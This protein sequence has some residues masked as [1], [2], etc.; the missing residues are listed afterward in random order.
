MKEQEGGDIDNIVK[1]VE[2]QSVMPE[3]GAVILQRV[4]KAEEIDQSHHDSSGQASLA[5][6]LLTSC[7]VLGGIRKAKV[8]L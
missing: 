7:L 2:P 4:G 5:V 1:G 3:R 8:I 6:H